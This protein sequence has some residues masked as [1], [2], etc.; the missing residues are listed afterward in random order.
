MSK[1][2]RNG[3]K[4]AGN[5]QLS[6]SLYDLREPD[7]RKAFLADANGYSRQYSMTEEERQLLVTHDWRGLA[8]AGISI[9]LLTKLAATLKVDFLEME[10]AMRG[11]SK[12]EFQQFLDKQAERNRRYAQLL[13]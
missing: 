6:R 1:A 9:Y 11:L 7:K 13:D 10:A 3:R 5:Y 2:D 12:Q 4:P 8:E